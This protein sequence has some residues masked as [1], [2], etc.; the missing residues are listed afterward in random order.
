MITQLSVADCVREVVCQALIR[1]MLM[2]VFVICL[3]L[4]GDVICSHY[5]FINQSDLLT[6]YHICILNDQCHIYLATKVE[7]QTH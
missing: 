3:T 5:S 4:H 1:Y 7:R 2:G 6:I